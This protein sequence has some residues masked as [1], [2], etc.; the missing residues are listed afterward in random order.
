MTRVSFCLADRDLLDPPEE[1]VNQVVDLMQYTP[2]GGVFYYDVFHLP[3]QVHHVNGW[4][5]RQVKWKVFSCLDEPSSWCKSASPVLVS[6]AVVHRASG[7]LL[8]YRE[9]RFRWQ[10]ASPLPPSWGVCETAWFCC[11]LGNATRGL[12]GCWRYDTDSR[13]SHF[14]IRL[15]GSKKSRRS[16][17]TGKQWRMD[18]ITDVSLD[19]AEDKISFRM[20]SFQAFVLMQETYANLPFKSWELRPMGQDSALYTINGALTNLSITIQVR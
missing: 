17:P 16:S 5:I 20:D 14:E 8:S 15:K 1:P 3:P 13:I 9:V 10:W 6:V 2:L 4:K 12:L 18:G 11:L 7:V 19:E